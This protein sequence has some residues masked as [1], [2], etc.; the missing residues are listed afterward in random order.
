MNSRRFSALTPNPM[1]MASIAGQERA[2]QQK[3]PVHVRFGSSAT[4]AIDAPRRSGEGVFIPAFSFPG[5][6]S[7]PGVILAK[8]QPKFPI[9]LRGLLAK[10]LLKQDR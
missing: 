3:R 4:E 8:H 1:I 7:V 5:F 9:A 2:S 10:P 6:D